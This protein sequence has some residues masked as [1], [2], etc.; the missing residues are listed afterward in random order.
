[1]QNHSN[2][3]SLYYITWK[4]KAVRSKQDLFLDILELQ[5]LSPLQNEDFWKEY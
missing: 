2:Y 4:M 5:G 1:M 3:V